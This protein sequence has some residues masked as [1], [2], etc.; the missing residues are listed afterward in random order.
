LP[1]ANIVR[2]DRGIGVRSRERWFAAPSPLFFAAVLLN[3]FPAVWFRYLPTTDGPDHLYNAWVINRLWTGSSEL[4][5]YF[6]INPVPVPNWFCE[7]FMA[8]VMF[9]IPAQQAERLFL[10]F[11]AVLLPICF[12]WAA[13]AVDRDTRGV[14]MLA[15]PLVF[16]LHL[17]WGFYNFCAGLAWYLAVIGFWLRF[18]HRMRVRHGVVLGALLLLAYFTHLLAWVHACLA[19]FVLWAYRVWIERR[20][21]DARLASARSA[22]WALAAAGPGLVLMAQYALA[23]SHDSGANVEFRTPMYAIL[24][25]GSLEFLNGPRLSA[26]RVVSAVAALL[27]WGLVLLLLWRWRR[28]EQSIASLSLLALAGVAASF[29]LFGPERMRG[30]QTLAERQLYF[31]VI[32]VALWICTQQLT[33]RVRAA[34]ALGAV[35]ASTGLHVARWPFYKVYD[36]AMSAFLASVSD[37]PMGGTRTLFTHSFGQLEAHVPTPS[38][39]AAIARHAGGYVALSR[40]MILL[41]N[42]GASTGNHAIVFANG[43]ASADAFLFWGDVPGV[44]EI[45]A[46]VPSFASHSGSLR[47]Y[48]AGRWAHAFVRE[49]VAPH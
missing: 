43:R 8:V 4:R 49:G 11:Y 37:V 1:I 31:A 17:H 19:I 41:S 15:L 40:D 6:A 30:M 12:W 42:H 21:R 35:A 33:P 36:R 9:A 28:K 20:S 45:S 25:L 26:E 13:R 32:P 44:P 2:P 7:A 3:A 14:E 24:R 23:R 22:A 27:F 16:N 29:C 18:G 39:E 34:I 5:A 38:G 47:H 46:A 10:C 48:R